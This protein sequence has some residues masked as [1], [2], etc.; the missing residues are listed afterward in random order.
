MIEDSTFKEASE[1]L[2]KRG[3]VIKEHIGKG[4]FGSVYRVYHETTNQTCVC[5]ILSQFG[6]F[7]NELQTL[8]MLNHPNIIKLYEQFDENDKFYLILEDCCEGDIINYMKTHNCSQEQIASFCYQII[9]ALYYLHSQNISH[10]DIK[11]SNILVDKNG[12]IKLADF[13]LSDNTFGYSK[14]CSGTKFYMAPEIF[15]K[16]PYNAYKADVWSLGITLYFIIFQ[17]FPFSNSMEWVKFVQY[18]IGQNTFPEIIDGNLDQVLRMSIIPQP[19][20]RH[21]VAELLSEI[22]K[23]PLLNRK[24]ISSLQLHLSDSRLKQAASIMKPRSSLLGSLTISR[25]R[26]KNNTLTLLHI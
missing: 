13:G 10:R 21:T 1:V 22:S 25:S 6:S 4:G 7:S 16:R 17:K 11:P 20:L 14:S 8:V 24:E 15:D 18:G 9:S 3:Y 23:C 5:K 19:H 2:A 12:T 26:S